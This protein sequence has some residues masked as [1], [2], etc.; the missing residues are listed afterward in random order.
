MNKQK[1][2]SRNQINK[3]IDMKSLTLIALLA[4]TFT[5]CAKPDDKSQL[6]ER[7]RIEGR[8]AAEADFQKQMKEKDALVQRA[9]EE[10]RARPRVRLTSSSRS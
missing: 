9:R 5:G 3:G 8:E 2:E 1:I 6:E 10:G 7:A 4:M